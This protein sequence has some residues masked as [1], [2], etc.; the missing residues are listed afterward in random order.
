MRHWN[1][2]LEVS[3]TGDDDIRK[4]TNS[5][6]LLPASSYY[7]TGGKNLCNETKPREVESLHD[8]IYSGVGGDWGNRVL[9]EY[10]VY[11][12]PD[13][14][15]AE[16]KTGDWGGP[17]GRRPRY[18]WWGRHESDETPRHRPAV[19]SRQGACH[20]ARPSLGPAA[21]G[22]NPADD[23]PWQTTLSGY[24]WILKRKSQ[25]RPTLAHCHNLIATSLLSGWIISVQHAEKWAED[26]SVPS[27]P[28]T[29]RGQKNP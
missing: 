19:A 6:L 2:G 22:R 28:V 18:L 12:S 11:D 13:M 15:A 9:G 20:R 29:K 1:R 8:D 21:L 7:Y 14:R 24:T 16:G 26:K 17:T 27:Q 3:R 5:L 23:P 4:I 10:C 25:G